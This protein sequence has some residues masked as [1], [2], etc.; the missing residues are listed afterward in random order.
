MLACHSLCAPAT[1]VLVATSREAGS[2]GSG[3]PGSTVCILPLK[4]LGTGE[5]RK[6]NKGGGK[7]PSL[8]H[9]RNLELGLSG[10]S[11]GKGG[12][13]GF[14]VRGDRVR[15]RARAFT[16]AHSP[17][18]GQRNPAM[19]PVLW[20]TRRSLSVLLANAASC[21]SGCSPSM[22]GLQMSPEYQWMPQC[23]GPLP[24]RL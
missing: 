19:N 15:K 21:Y 7:K 24:P 3:S 10:C 18:E 22:T 2:S 12:G 5:K 1:T 16:M 9:W 4:L 11:E 17:R 8:R 6:K 14:R 23:E 13:R 20:G